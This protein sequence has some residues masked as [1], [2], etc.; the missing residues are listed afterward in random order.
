MSRPGYNTS[1]RLML[2]F[3]ELDLKSAEISYWASKYQWC[4]KTFLERSLAAREARHQLLEAYGLACFVPGTDIHEQFGN[5]CLT[6]IEHRNLLLR[7]R[8]VYRAPEL[9]LKF[10]MKGLHRM[11]DADRG[12]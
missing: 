11:S 12:Q 7:L 2:N 9:R 5:A 8:E 1:S 3:F 4:R 6:I 10:A